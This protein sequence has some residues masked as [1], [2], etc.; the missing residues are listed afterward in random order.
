MPLSPPVMRATLPSSLPLPRST[1]PSALGRGSI[2]ASMPGC[3]SCSWGGSVCFFWSF[4]FFA[5]SPPSPS[6]PS[7]WNLSSAL[8]TPPRRGEGF[9]DRRSMPSHR[10]LVHMGFGELRELLVGHLFFLESPLQERR[11]HLLAEHLGVGADRAVAG[12]L[13]VLDPLRGGD[14]AGVDHL[15]IALHLDHLVAFLDQP[16]HPLARMPLGTV[17]QVLEDLLQAAHL[18]LRLPQM[19]LE[20]LLEIGRRGPLGHL[21]KRVDQLRLGA[22]EIFELFEVE[23]FQGFE[24]HG[25]SWRVLQSWKIHLRVSAKGG[26]NEGWLRKKRA[27]WALT[28]GPSPASGRGVW[29]RGFAVRGRC[30]ARRTG[31]LHPSPARGRGAG[32]EGSYVPVARR[33]SVSI[34]SSSSR[35]GPG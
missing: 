2:S 32:G 16:L 5:I 12:D 17:A 18:L 11:M 27:A 14:E 21:G 4:S 10:L 20:T 26:R 31:N 33:S 29:D 3:R 24:F 25:S 19:L 1:R 6:S 34:H 13:V 23:V 30:E 35:C 28:P 15:G 22:V 8:R 9:G 7:A